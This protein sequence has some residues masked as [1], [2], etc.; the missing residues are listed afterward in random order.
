MTHRRPTRAL[1]IIGLVLISLLHVDSPSVH[2][3]TLDRMGGVD[4][5]ETAAMVARRVV[6]EGMAGSTVLLTTG[7][8]YP[9]AISAGGWRGEAAVVLTKRREIPSVSLELLTENWVRDVYVI[10]GPS[11]IDESIVER[12]RSLGKSVTRLWGADRFGTS[13]EVSK[14]TNPSKSMSLIWV[15]PGNSFSDQLIAAA[16][17]RRSGGAFLTVPESGVLNTDTSAEI[18]RLARDGAEIRVVDH[19]SQLLRMNVPKLK[20]VNFYGDIYQITVDTQAA[21]PS[22]IVASGENWPD[23]LGGT[24]LVNTSRG[25][26]LSRRSCSPTGVSTRL[27]RAERL[28]VLGG[29]AAL[30]SASVRGASCPASPPPSWVTPPT[31]SNIHLSVGMTRSLEYLAARGHL[32]MHPGQ[33]VSARVTGGTGKC[34]V[35]STVVRGTAVGTCLLDVRVAGAGRTLTV[36]VVSSPP[37]TSTDRSGPALL[38][39]KPVYIRFSD[40]PDMSRDTNGQIASFVQGIADFFA[41]Q[42]P[43][44]AL[45]VDTTNGVPDVQHIVVPMTTAEFLNRWRGE[46]DRM[47]AGMGPL[48][49]ILI[50]MGF[51]PGITGFYSD[52]TLGQKIDQI[53]RIYVGIVEAPRGPYRS[54]NSNIDGGCA[55]SSG[56]AFVVYFVRELDGADCTVNQKQPMTYRGSMVDWIG[57]DAFRLLVDILNGNRDCDR[58]ITDR[59]AVPLNDRPSSITSPHDPIGYPYAVGSRFPRVL[60]PFRRFYFRISSG[61][62]AGDPCTDLLYSPYISEWSSTDV[63][64]DRLLGRSSKDLPDDVTGP[65]VRVLYVLPANA[66]DHQWDVNGFLHETAASANEWLFANGGRS[67]RFDTFGERLDVGFV[68]LPMAEQ[69]LWFRADG[70]KCSPNEMC[71]D[72]RRLMDVLEDLDVLSDGKIHVVVWGGQLMPASIRNVGCAG[73]M[74]DRRAVFM[75]P[76]LRFPLTS[77]SGCLSSAV[78]GVPVSSNSLGLVMIHEIFHVFGGVDNRAPDADG[79]FHIG[80]DPSDLMG[81]SVGIVRLDPKRR[82]YWGHGRS[83]LLDLSKDAHL[84]RGPSSLER[85]APLVIPSEWWMDYPQQW[86][87][88]RGLP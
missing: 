62:F 35:D 59:Y 70:S 49:P 24:R 63:H 66:P 77:H 78:T 58:T 42:H 5:Y 68:R 12:L 79:G 3:T 11:V 71:P 53:E 87:P 16:A 19:R 41:S 85:P 20:R 80:N 39:L 55:S 48:G 7:E 14:V 23:A 81:G 26:I 75:S 13:V 36:N 67:V 86:N 44:F 84:V 50:D 82:N 22:T 76:M 27:Q 29:Q 37:R 45:R 21:S 43:G 57:F 34:V 17:A 54:P 6:S 64:N 2:A 88:L 52:G 47:K 74:P 1:L 46:T 9:D 32:L 60:D 31:K 40:S 10:G 83:D 38:D 30:S 25:M 61:P 69:E 28:I 73:A 4:R 18:D 33:A 56:N 8:N 15:A 65:Q 51:D 72:P